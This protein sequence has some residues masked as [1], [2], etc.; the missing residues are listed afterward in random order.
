MLDDQDY[1]TG[2]FK[3]V[4]D[5]Y[6]LQSNETDLEIPQGLFKAQLVNGIWV[7]VTAE[8]F[9]GSENVPTEPT[10]EM[11]AINALGLVLAKY[12]ANGGGSNV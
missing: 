8:E 2:D 5:D 3:Y 10:T 6:E 11:Q 1:W 7:G 9:F 12:I 4:T